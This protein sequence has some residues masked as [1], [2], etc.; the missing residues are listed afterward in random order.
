MLLPG[1]SRLEITPG[2][3]R[4]Q[5]VTNLITICMLPVQRLGHVAIRVRDID[6]AISFYTSLGMR[7]VWKAT[8]WSYLEAGKSHTGL[9]LLGPDYQA[10]GPH[11]A[12]HFRD[13]KD[14]DDVHCK[15]R[16]GG[17]QVGNV[18]GHRD[19]TASFYLQDPDGNWLEMLYEPPEGIPDNQPEVHRSL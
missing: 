7:V 8:D 6:R 2:A 16:Q 3:L 13:R 14:I 18:C 10:A 19:G 12:F 11:F 9:A 4:L 15:L 1:C 5:N 17:I